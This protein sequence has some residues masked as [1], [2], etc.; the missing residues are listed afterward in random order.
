MPRATS[1]GKAIIALQLVS[2]LAVIG[3]IGY[4]VIVIGLSNRD[5]PVAAVCPVGTCPN[6][7]FVPYKDC[8]RTEYDPAIETCM[9]ANHCTTPLPCA[10]QADGSSACPGTAGGGVCPPGV[11]CGCSTYQL[12]PDEIRAFFVPYRFNGVLY[13]GQNAV[14]VNT[15]NQIGWDPALQAGYPS[16][17]RACVLDASSLGRA[18]NKTCLEGYLT[19]FNNG[20]YGCAVG[21][22]CPVGQHPVWDYTTETAV[23]RVVPTWPAWRE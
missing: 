8:S 10:V 7:L 4:L 22:G 9:P 17:E 23:C 21:Q 19:L 6:G 11:D 5:I 1:A 20:L 18:A 14:D 15:V 3:F 12:C 2:L 13:F 16:Q